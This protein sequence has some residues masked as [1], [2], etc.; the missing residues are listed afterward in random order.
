MVA[1]KDTLF[2]RFLAPIFNTFLLDREALLKTYQSLDWE[3]ESDRLRDANLVYPDYYRSQNFHGIERGYLNPGAAVS[4]DPITQYV[5]PPNETWVR[6]S[7]I[8]GIRSRPRRILDVGCGTGTT[9]LMLKRAFPQAEV[10]GI[11]LSPYMLV[12]AEHKA[13]QANLPI[14]FGH[15]NAEHTSFADADFDLVTAV[16]LFHE[17][18]P[19]IACQILQEAFRLLKPGGEVMVLDGNQLVLRHTDWLTEVFEEPYIKAYAAGTVDDWMETTGFRA[20]QTDNVWG[21]HQLTRGVKPLPGESS[22]TV[23][24]SEQE[25]IF[26]KQWAMG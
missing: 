20:V 7:L 9:T 17:T 14:H 23:S 8:D 26:D 5:L 2:E 24:Y 25:A 12:M 6:Q 15:A 18:P 21:I 1:R 13:Q 3:K 16:L 4:Y 22:H 11:D 19:A 10:V